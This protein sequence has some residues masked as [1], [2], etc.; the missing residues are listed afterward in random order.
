MKYHKYTDYKSLENINKIYGF[1]M[2]EARECYV[3]FSKEFK[4]RNC[5][6]CDSDDYTKM[7]KFLDLYEVALCNVCSASYVNPAPSLNAL[8]YYYNNAQSTKIFATLNANQNNVPIQ[9]SRIDFIAPFV[10]SQIKS[11]GKINILEVGCSS[12][13]LLCNIRKFLEQND[14]ENCV[15]LVSIDLDKNAINIAS[16]KCGGGGVICAFMR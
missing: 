2:R 10:E 14:L 6:V 7:P 1:R 13:T 11:K 8:D 15:N 5:P 16:S 12:G 3:K 4:H 9:D